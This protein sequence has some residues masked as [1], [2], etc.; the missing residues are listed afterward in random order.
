MAD[1]NKSSISPEKVK[2]FMAKKQLVKPVK[3][4]K[5]D[6]LP[7]TPEN[8]MKPESEKIIKSESEKSVKLVKPVKPVKPI[9]P[10]KPTN[11]DQV[12]MPLYSSMLGRQIHQSAK[13]EK[14]QMFKIAR[15]AIGQKKLYKKHTFVDSSSMI[16]SNNDDEESKVYTFKIDPY[17]LQIL[18]A[19]TNFETLI[20]MGPTGIGKSMRIPTWVFDAIC[21][22][23]QV[24]VTVPTRKAT[25]NLYKYQ[26]QVRPDLNIGCAFNSQKFY[27]KQSNI[28]YATTAH[29]AQSFLGIIK[30]AIKNKVPFSQVKFPK[31]LMVDEAHDGKSDT[32]L[33]LKIVK[34]L[35]RHGV[36]ILL[37]ICSA[38]ITKE[39][40]QR[41][42][43]QATAIE[44]KET[45]LP[46]ETIY[47]NCDYSTDPEDIKELYGDMLRI[48]SRE[49]M[50]NPCTNKLV[51]LPGSNEIN[52]FIT[53]AR[54][55]KCQGGL[56]FGKAVFCPAYSN[57]QDEELQLAFEDPPIGLCKI[58]VATPIFEHSVTIKDIAY[59]LSC[60]FDKVMNTDGQNESQSLDLT[61]IAQGQADQQKGRTGRTC[62]GV[63][64]RMFTEESYMRRRVTCRQEIDCL[65]LHQPILKLLNADLNP[66]E[67]LDDQLQKRLDESYK[68]LLDRGLIE[69]SQ[70]GE[71]L[72][73]EFSRGREPLRE[74][75]SRG[76]EPMITDSSAA[77]SKDSF[78]F[79]FDDYKNEE[80][81]KPILETKYF[82]TELGMFVQKFPMNIRTGIFIHNLITI[83]DPAS[84]LA[85][86]I[87]A[88]TFDLNQPIFYISPRT[89]DETSSEH[90]ARVQSDKKKYYKFIGSCDFETKLR[91][92]VSMM[93][94]CS[95]GDN[96]RIVSADSKASYFEWART[97]GMNNKLLKEWRSNV[98]KILEKLD[99]AVSTNYNIIKNFS[100]VIESL[101]VP[102]MN[103]FADRTFENKTG[104]YMPYQEKSKENLS[105]ERMFI[106]SGKFQIDNKGINNTFGY[107]STRKSK[108]EEPVHIIS[109]TV[110]RRQTNRGILF[111]LG[112][113]YLPRKINRLFV[114]KR[115]AEIKEKI[116]REELE[117]QIITEKKRA[118]Q[119][120]DSHIFDDVKGRLPY[121]ELPETKL[122]DYS[123]L[124]PS[125]IP[126]DSDDESDE[127]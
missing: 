15:I 92:Y 88:A 37:I 19:I 32:A 79:I 38:T 66:R 124:D 36:S 125:F 45:T 16:N 41:M 29:L 14:E 7:I 49:Q 53:A 13:P 64:Y 57:L 122:E 84:L 62:P 30:S 72:R 83:K 73:E 108:I 91:I 111:F 22:D 101:E 93:N 3:P 6:F 105:R 123:Y 78:D 34:W 1:Q 58:V 80:I 86:V 87:L 48:L 51:F 5:S 27:N 109:L 31:V 71:P 50:T 117:R 39:Y 69:P 2:A 89:R 24:M 99:I 116:A 75:F 90:T 21:Q 17:K 85:G 102:F 81:L 54:E 52:N 112:D 95:E 12:T 107:E 23:E 59:V 63:C 100:V 76:G 118:K 127:Y 115:D 77:N 42:F 68:Y 120:K 10:V 74:E 33:L 67:I 60:G 47:H 94:E 61:E 106:G 4:V 46:V 11:I 40:F 28:V 121:H 119:M 35:R 9:K 18:D 25:E 44:I 97:N 104:E 82:V 126:S 65:P 70:D 8:I 96:A 113:I 55:F 114:E 20:F 26:K 110:T 43:P 103:T 56:V 98:R